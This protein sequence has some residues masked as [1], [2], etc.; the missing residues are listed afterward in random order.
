MVEEITTKKIKESIAMGVTTL[1]NDGVGD[2]ENNEQE[3]GGNEH[4]DNNLK[5]VEQLVS[6]QDFDEKKRLIGPMIKDLHEVDI[7]SNDLVDE[8]L[9]KKEGNDEDNGQ[10]MDA[11]EEYLKHASILLSSLDKTLVRASN[12]VKEVKAESKKQKRLDCFFCKK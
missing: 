2:T 3:T 9:Q 6:G 11:A 4:K 7:I 1:D 8:M 12:A 5:N 10:T